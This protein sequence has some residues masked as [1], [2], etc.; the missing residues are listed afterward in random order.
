MSTTTQSL[1]I[2]LPA[3]GSSRLLTHGDVSVVCE[4]SDSRPR[5]RIRG[6][7]ARQQVEVRSLVRASVLSILV[8][9]GARQAD[10]WVSS[11]SVL[12]TVWGRSASPSVVHTT[13][14]RIRNTLRDADLDPEML[15]VR[16]GFARLRPPVHSPAREA[17]VE[18]LNRA[19]ARVRR[20][21][22]GASAALTRAARSVAATDG[23][24]LSAE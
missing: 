5:V 11:A 12:R 1:R 4:F 2:Q 7:R 17:L 3:T 24:W 23:L 16:D 22:P 19:L 15:E 10:R 20:G 13:L 18:E 6:P 8:V 14:Y 9:E 21:E